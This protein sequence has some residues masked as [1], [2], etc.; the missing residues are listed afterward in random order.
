MAETFGTIDG[1]EYR[2]DWDEQP[3]R[4]KSIALVFWLLEP[5]A[6]GNMMLS[7]ILLFFF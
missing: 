7:L 6:S 1:R 3:A 2:T 4:T 5:A